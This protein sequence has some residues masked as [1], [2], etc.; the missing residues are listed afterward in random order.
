MNEQVKMC[1]TSLIIKGLQIKR[2]MKYRAHLPDRQKLKILGNTYIGEDRAE[3]KLYT[4]H[5][6]KANALFGM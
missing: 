2:I 3:D 6:V 4:L 1:S 5:Q